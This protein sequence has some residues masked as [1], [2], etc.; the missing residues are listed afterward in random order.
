MEDFKKINRRRAI[1]ALGTG[2]FAFGL[3]GNW[4]DAAT[5]QIAYREDDPI[6]K[7]PK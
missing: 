3:T 5:R 4:S 1:G 2:I 7:Y 6:N